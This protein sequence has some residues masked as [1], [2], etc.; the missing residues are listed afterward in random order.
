M[1]ILYYTIFDIILYTLYF[2]VQKQYS[3]KR[4]KPQFLITIFFQWKYFQNDLKFC[5]KMYNKQQKIWKIK[6]K[7]KN[8]FWIPLRHLYAI[9]YFIEI[10][11]TPRLGV[12]YNNYEYQMGDFF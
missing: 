7:A 5:N 11:W 2:I 8:E 9:Y 4:A 1:F 12:F 3:W 10:A 6:K